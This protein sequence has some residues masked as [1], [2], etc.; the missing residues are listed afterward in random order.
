MTVTDSD[1]NS[2]DSTNSTVPEIKDSNA[3]K[4]ITWIGIAMVITGLLMIFNAGENHP[5]VMIL[6][7]LSLVTGAFTAVIAKFYTWWKNS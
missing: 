2:I 7:M 6:G 1:Q 3:I 5:W 4:V